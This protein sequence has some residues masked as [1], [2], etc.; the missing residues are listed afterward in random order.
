MTQRMVGAYDSRE[1]AVIALNGELETL[2]EEIGWVSDSEQQAE[3]L[4]DENLVVK[5]GEFFY[6]YD[7][8]GLFAMECGV[9]DTE[10]C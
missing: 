7:E 3:Y 6:Y 4:I 10:E 2:K 1:H 5:D 9:F 8:D